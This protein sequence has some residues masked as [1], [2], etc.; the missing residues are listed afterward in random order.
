M[1]GGSKILLAESLFDEDVEVLETL[2]KETQIQFSLAKIC[3]SNGVLDYSSL[4]ATEEN[5]TKEFA[6]FVFPQVN[7]FGLLEDVDALTD[8][9][10]GAACVRSHRSIPC[11]LPL[12]V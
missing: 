4:Q 3:P 10:R 1:V 11:F 2:A 12:V 9:A 8:F 7:K 5:A 6:A